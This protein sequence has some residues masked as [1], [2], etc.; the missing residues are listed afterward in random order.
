MQILAVTAQ[1]DD[2]ITDQLSRAVIG[3]LAAAVDREKRMRQMR[4]AAQTRLI[5]R[6]TNGVNRLVFEKHNSSPN[7]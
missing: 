2:R 3:R 1:V 4:R 6:A 7:E 5:G